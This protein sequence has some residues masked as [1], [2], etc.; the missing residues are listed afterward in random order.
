VPVTF[1]HPFRVVRLRILTV[2]LL[3]IW[4]VLALVALVQ[5]LA[6]SFSV[7]AALCLIALYFLTIGLLPRPRSPT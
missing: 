1:V 4:A 3:A 7:T 5:D 2:A 6:P